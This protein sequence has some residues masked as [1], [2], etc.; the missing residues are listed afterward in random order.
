MKSSIKQILKNT[1]TMTDSGTRI[2]ANAEIM[3]ENGTVLSAKAIEIADK[4]SILADKA[5]V[6]ADDLHK[7]IEKFGGSLTGA[8]ATA[9]GFDGID[10]RFIRETKPGRFRAEV[11]AGFHVGESNYHVGLWDAFETNKLIAQQGR[12]LTDKLE[13]RYGVY[14]SQL[15]LGVHYAVSP[16]VTIRGDIFDVNDPRFDLRARFAIGKDYSAWLGLDRVFGGTRPSIGIGI[17]K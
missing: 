5:G 17:K 3:T 13:L 8:A 1:E 15:G 11:E 2:A 9:I 10:G 6:L 7:L 16:G 4:A 14:A 12:N